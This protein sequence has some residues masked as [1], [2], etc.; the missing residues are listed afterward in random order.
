MSDITA[1]V[2]ATDIRPE[3]EPRTPR[4]MLRPGLALGAVVL[5]DFLLFDHNIGI[6][7]AIFMAALA[8]ALILATRKYD[9]T[10]WIACA[11]LAFA[12]LPLVEHASFI[13]FLVAATGLAAFAVLIAGGGPNPSD[14]IRPVLALVL[15]GPFQV[16]H[17]LAFARREDLK[18]KPGALQAWLLPAGC[19]VV[20]A[21]LFAEAN[22]LIE[23]WFARI[24][25]A[26]IFEG[27]S[28]DRTVVWILLLC[29]SWPIIVPRLRK[30]RVRAAPV[31]GEG[32]EAET[33]LR[34]FT[35][36]AV[37]RS[38]ILFNIMFGVQTA[39]D[40]AFLWGGVS[41][42]EGITHAAYAHR[43]AY[44]L[45]VTALLA[46]GFV[47]IAMPANRETSPTVKWLVL[48]WI[49]QNVM[50]VI[51]S[52]LRLDLY[53]EAYS[54]TLL[55]T[56]AFIWMGLVAT[57]LVLII[58]RIVLNKSNSWL[59]GTNLIAL[60]A[61][62]YISSLV[63]FAALVA[64]YN[65]DRAISNGHE[66]DRSYLV[67]LGPD[68]IPA[69]DRLI[70]LAPAFAAEIA[71][72]AEYMATGQAFHMTAWRAW[73]FRD[74]RLQRYLVRRQLDKTQPMSEETPTESGD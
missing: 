51:S 42:P 35:P 45:I 2:E 68:A 65:V 55:R 56:A 7:L 44:P 43:G 74:W 8:A 71:S 11:V 6:S 33:T 66:L 3:A 15:R 9:K 5:G 12:L 31:A 52:I 23:S 27:M 63:N 61:T 1:A 29:C 30:R 60:G 14:L 47:L 13:A 46:A 4:S 50:L 17:D 57:G 39:M 64:S 19:G 24:D 38:L 62:L 49:V 10:T 37:L 73:T 53:I 18:P 54:L 28:F 16:F 69:M 25:L 58:A 21:I 41:L 40:F 36:A 59:V 72:D 67:S 32:P 20:F 48:A 26:R 34:L 70:R 22:P